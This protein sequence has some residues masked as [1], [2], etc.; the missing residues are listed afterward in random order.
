MSTPRDKEVAIFISYRRDGGDSYARSLYLSLER[1]FDHDSIFFDRRNIGAGQDFPEEI[2]GACATAGVFLIVIS[3]RW[4]EQLNARAQAKPDELDYVREEVKLALKRHA[5]RECFVIPVLMGGAPFPTSA[6]VNQAA[7][8]DVAGLLTMDAFGLHESAHEAWESE[9]KRLRDL[10]TRQ[11]PQQHLKACTWLGADKLREI[12]ESCGTQHALPLRTAFYRA[13]HNDVRKTSADVAALA[14]GAAAGDV[15]RM[16]EHLAQKPPD[17]SGVQALHQFAAHLAAGNSLDDLRRKLLKDWLTAQLGE[18]AAGNLMVKCRPWESRPGNCYLFVDH[19]Q[20][21][22]DP[23][24]GKLYV[25]AGGKDFKAF[26]VTSLRKTDVDDQSDAAFRLLRG[27]MVKCVANNVADPHLVL[28]VGIDNPNISQPIEKLTYVDELGDKL[29]LGKRHLILRR[30]TTRLK[31]PYRTGEVAKSAQQ[32]LDRVACSGL[33]VSW[34]EPDKLNEQGFTCQMERDQDA[35]CFGVKPTE[36]TPD[37]AKAAG[38]AAISHD[39]PFA[40]WVL[41]DREPWTAPDDECMVS[42]LGGLRNVDESLRKLYFTREKQGF[43]PNH[44]SSKLAFI[45]DDPSRNPHAMKFPLR[46]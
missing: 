10:V 1:Y 5:K 11:L 20:F 2:A 14:N 42:D 39:I 22:K 27:A 36:H 12:L 25:P 46:G 17:T 35:V 3:P 38:R 30:L 43:A 31:D 26:R 21:G 8:D 44:Y 4:L 23:M 34:L 37:M 7:L 13:L 41:P 16:L 15:S 32:L 6:A 40:C 18:A 29:L 9:V 19:A 28:E 45:W 24:E 33:R